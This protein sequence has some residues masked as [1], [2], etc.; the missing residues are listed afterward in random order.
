LV[1]FQIALP[2]IQAL[3]FL[4]FVG[5][6]PQLLPVALVNNDISGKAG[7]ELAQ[8]VNGSN[9]LQ[10]DFFTNETEAYVSVA[11]GPRMALFVIPSN[12]TSALDTTMKCPSC[13]TSDFSKVALFLDY[14]DYQIT[15]V[16]ESYLESSLRTLVLNRYNT[17]WKLYEAHAIYGESDTQYVRFVAP[18]YLSY[19]AFCFAMFLTVLTFMWERRNGCLERGFVAGL[20]PWVIIISNLVLFVIV[21]FVQAVIMLLLTLAVFKLEVRGSMG[22]LVLTLWLV[23][24][25]GLSF[26]Q[27]ISVLAPNEA[28]AIQVSVGVSFLVLSLGGILWPLFSVPDSISWI[29]DVLPVTWAAAAFRDIYTRGW[30][31]KH[32]Y[33]WVVIMG[34]L[35]WNIFMVVVMIVLVKAH[36]K[37]FVCCCDKRKSMKV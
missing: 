28:I 27:L 37:L 35:L 17:T 33:V 34:S 20:R 13:V 25:T 14:G 11:D 30:G 8:L 36:K 5:D 10:M 15:K 7:M 32:T 16:I 9:V 23:A 31:V 3:I 24:T 18:G 22:L 6:A 12:F 26:G 29:S 1:L 21:I 19:T 2:T 4:L